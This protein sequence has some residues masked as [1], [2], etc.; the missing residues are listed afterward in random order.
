VWNEHEGEWDEEEK[1]SLG[2][3]T[4]FCMGF[5]DG[6]FLPVLRCTGY[7]TGGGYMFDG[8]IAVLA[9]SITC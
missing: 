5:C 9:A 7:G 6:D 4:G 8:M 3:R 2:A 1:M